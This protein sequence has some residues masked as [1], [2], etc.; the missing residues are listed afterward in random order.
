MST[1]DLNEVCLDQPLTADRE[2]ADPGVLELDDPVV[3]EV[4]DCLTLALH[5]EIPKDVG[6]LLRAKPLTEGAAIEVGHSGGD[7]GDGD[8]LLHLLLLA[9]PRFVAIQDWVC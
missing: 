2:A 4:F 6:Q 1:N 7:A 8:A 9:W 3:L 5:P